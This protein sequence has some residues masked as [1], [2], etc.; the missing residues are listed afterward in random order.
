C[1]N[2][3]S[4]RTAHF[5]SI[6]NTYEFPTHVICDFFAAFTCVHS[7][8]SLLLLGVLVEIWLLLWF[9]VSRQV[10]VATYCTS[11][12]IPHGP[13]HVQQKRK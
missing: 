2:V 9:P 10:V 7:P 3:A 12:Q 13:V 4:Q 11:M 1:R 5:Q 8:S 6:L